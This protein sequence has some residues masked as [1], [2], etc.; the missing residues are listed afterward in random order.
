MHYRMNPPPSLD[1][2]HPSNRNRG[3]REPFVDGEEVELPPCP[4][5]DSPRTSVVRWPTAAG[6]SWFHSGTGACLDCGAR[7]SI[8]VE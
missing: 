5:C 3:S 2:R 1:P 6:Q 7:F 4:D 8:C